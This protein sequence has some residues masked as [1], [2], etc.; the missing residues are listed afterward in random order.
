MSEPVRVNASTHAGYKPPKI[1]SRR[2]SRPMLAIFLVV[3]L[4]W[5][6]LAVSARIPRS[7]IG[8]A[9]GPSSAGASYVPETL[10]WRQRT[11]EEWAASDFL[12]TGYAAASGVTLAQAVFQ[13][14]RAG[15]FDDDTRPIEAMAGLDAD[16][17]GDT[18][19]V[20]G[21][22]HSAMTGKLL[23]NDGHATFVETEAGA[24]SDA[25]LGASVAL[26]AF[27]ADGDGDSDV[28]AAIGGGTSR[29]LRNDGL[30]RFA[31]TEAG[32]FDDEIDNCGELLPFDADGDGDIDLATGHTYAG[33]AVYLNDGNGRFTFLR[34]GDFYTC[35]R[36]MAA[37]DADK[38]GDMDLALPGELYRND[39]AGHLTLTPAGDFDSATGSDLAAFDAE[40]DGD[41][42]LAVP[43]ALYLSNADGSFTL[44]DAGAFDDSGGYRL[45][46]F[47]AD[48][49]GDSDLA[50]GRSSP[51]SNALFIND[52]AGVFAQ[53]DA[54]DFDDNP[55]YSTPM[56]AL[57]ADDD[58]R[59]DLAGVSGARGFLFRNQGEASFDL[60]D[61]GAL[62]NEARVTKAIAAFDANGDAFPDLAIAG[63]PNALFVNDGGGT[64]LAADSGD[65]ANAGHVVA[66]ATFDADGDG[67]IDLATGNSQEQSGEANH[68]LLNDG[69]GRLVVAEA[70]DFDNPILATTAVAAVDVDGDGDMDLAVANTGAANALY[71]NDGAAQFTQA[72]AGDFDDDAGSTYALV[73]FDADG[74]GDPD[75]ATPGKL[76]LNDGAG[77]FSLTDSAAFGASGAG[78]AVLVAFD[79]NGD[80]AIDLAGLGALFLNDGQG[81]FSVRTFGPSNWQG[82]QA[83]VALDYDHDGDVDLATGP[84]LS[85][86]VVPRIDDCLFANDGAANF[87]AVAAGDLELREDGVAALVALDA[88]MD[89]DLDL[90]RPGRVMA[91]EN[92]Y[93]TGSITS[94]IIDPAQLVSHIRPPGRVADAGRPGVD[95]RPHG[96]T[97][98][99]LGRGQRRRDPRLCR[100]PTRRERTD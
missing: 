16:G 88:D 78:L 37:L 63:Q 3:C 75:L 61:A 71:L 92:Q 10:T 2:S 76:F 45:L 31:L 13:Q 51:Q 28:A 84:N 47:D 46:P 22:T 43:G 17:D 81:R 72:D 15:D 30:G 27:D 99:R 35:S 20:L 33:I 32:D 5:P 41:V 62:S 96:D 97:L 26:A 67:D 77:H 36:P 53:A 89:G 12:N 29:L 11:A 7:P 86:T 40:S 14:T 74:D 9:I 39:G 56:V 64:F 42:N 34:N 98:R 73:S 82:V 58:G 79:A 54:G 4:A 50:V 38:D 70:G 23:L 66:L 57:D 25:A 90:A 6:A 87:T 69:A 49:D 85:D 1:P 24:L 44:A 55:P 18:D 65:L 19:L 100:R 91:Y 83:M 94:P 21:V 48:G 80:G 60:V 52:G 93:E 59:L 68:L 8:P 95:A